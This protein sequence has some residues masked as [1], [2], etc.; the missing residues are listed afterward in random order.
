MTT[1]SNRRKAAL[2]GC[3]MIADTHLTALL[4]A[5]AD[6][7][8]VF[9]RNRERAADFAAKHGMRAYDSLDALLDDDIDIVS[10]CTPSGTH[11]SLAETVME[12]G[13]HAIVEKPMALTAAECQRIIG[14]EQK[15][16]KFCAP[17]SQLRFSPVYRQVKAAIDE[18]RFGR[19]IL[20]LLSMKY[21]RA[22]SYYAGSWR[23]TVAMDGG[24]ALMNQGIHGIDMMCGLLGYPTLVSGHAA[25]LLHDIEVEDTAVANLVFPDG[26]LGVID[27]S[28]A[29]TYAKPRRLELCGTRA[30]VTIEE[31]A[32]IHAEGIE[33]LCHTVSGYKS[34]SD[35]TAITTDLHEYQFRN[36]LAAAAG[37][38]PLYYTSREAM[39]T[40][41]VIAA[42][43]ESSR[44]QNSISL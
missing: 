44:T 13:K 4:N 3:G 31:D 36:I 24:G 40:V 17:I 34:F 2:I 38:E 12:H 29:V 35:P 25:T 43:Y 14:V 37:E 5:G 18:G 21:Y 22:P 16:G 33:L 19:M 30:S 8:G 42:I 39:R 7:V 6:A 28:T 32:I 15:T 20:G 41:D 10:V 9:D 26:T 11:A 27:G 23:G 1:A